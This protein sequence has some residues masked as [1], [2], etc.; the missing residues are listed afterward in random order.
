[1]LAGG[2][3]TDLNPLDNGGEG[4]AILVLDPKD[5]KVLRAF[6][7]DSLENS[8]KFGSGV[9][10]ASPHMGMIISEPTL[11]RTLDKASSYAQYITGKA[12]AADN[13][14]NIFAVF[15]EEPMA[16]SQV[17]RLSP[18][19]WKIRMVATL[20]SSLASVASSVSNY[21]VPY[22]VALEKDEDSIWVAGGTSDVTTRKENAN[23]PGVL[24]N[25]LQMIF[26]FKT[27]DGQNTP[28]SRND[29]QSLGKL[30]GSVM[31]RDGNGWYIPL[32]KPGLNFA[33]YVSTKPLLVNGTL[34]VS[35]FTTTK[36]DLTGVDDLCA[37]S[38]RRVDG[39]SRIYALSARD[40]SAN[41]WNSNDTYKKK[42][43]QIDGVRITGLTSVNGIRNDDGSST[44]LASFDGMEG[45]VLPKL[46]Q[47]N[48]NYVNGFSAI[49][50]KTL[51]G[52]TRTDLS[53][54]QSTIIYWLKK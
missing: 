36:F 9:R 31:T 11:F 35:T 12:Y 23:D 53:P 1:V 10:G 52:K 2:V 22:G 45:G 37:A 44:I 8:S 33:E 17:N 6:G 51:P 41:L 48:A 38:N 40:G 54:G 16:D 46:D 4:A 14:G 7:G 47:K 29:L 39:Y 49:E 28:L 26:A 50:I 20:Q 43:I 18:D 3:Q 24:S 42:Y 21:A 15:F 25:D 34:F 13:R 27:S 19:K 32:D 30:P 5:G